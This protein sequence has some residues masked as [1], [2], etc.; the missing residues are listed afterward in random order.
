MEPF[1]SPPET[2]TPQ[3]NGNLLDGA[4]VEWRWATAADHAQ[5]WAGTETRV[6]YDPAAS[7]F[8][9]IIRV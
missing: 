4:G 3:A 1:S 7:L 9:R 5:V 2:Y 8:R 6:I